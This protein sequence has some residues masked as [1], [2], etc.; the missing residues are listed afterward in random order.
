LDIQ[1]P[2]KIIKENYLKALEFRYP[3]WIP[4]EIIFSPAGWKYHREKLEKI[5]IRHPLL[6]G[7]YKKGSKNFDDIP[8]VYRKGYFRDN[9]GCLWNNI[10][11]GLEGRIVEHPLADWKALDTYELPDYLTQTERGERDWRQIKKDVEENRRKGLLTVGDGERLFDRL[12]FL[13]GFK[14]LMI[15]IMTDDLHL[16]RLID[17]LLA[18]E[19]KLVKKWLE[20]KVDLI[21]FHTDIG[22]QQGLMINPMKFRKYIKPLYKELFMTCRKADT[23]VYLSSDGRIL[24]IVDDLVEC[25]VS[26]HDPQLRANTL[27]G[28]AK[29][30]KGK[31]CIDVDLDRQMFAFCTTNDI[32]QQ[33]KEV[34]EKLSLPEGG[35]MMKT[36]ITGT[37]VP[38]ENIEALCQSMETFCIGKR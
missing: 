18:Y 23:H 21:G 17:M 12:Y 5:V 19:M 26:V 37:N 32:K 35:L 27:E 1:Y 36:E 7:N 29:F 16:P 11:E 25:G 22:T 28:I 15:D 14:N 13:R 30:Y 4:C 8:P 33:V 10:Q 38:L 3:E 2:N 24:D 6:F 20:I 34:V 9:W 31:M